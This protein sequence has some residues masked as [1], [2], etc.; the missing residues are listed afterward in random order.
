MALAPRDGPEHAGLFEALA[1][2]GFASSFDYARS[3]KQ[4]LVAKLGIAHPHGVFLEVGGLDSD[5][6]DHGGSIRLQ[7]A[8]I[9]DQLFDLATVQFGL[10]RQDP[11]ALGGWVASRV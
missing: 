2:H 7:G 9:G 8:E 5:G 4:M 10:M 6:F 11:A 3:D 1:D